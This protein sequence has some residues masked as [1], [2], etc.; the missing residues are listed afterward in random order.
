M[1]IISC[2]AL[3]KIM[4]KVKVTLSLD[5]DIYTT[6]KVY[7][8]QAGLSLSDLVD[9]MMLK[10]LKNFELFKKLQKLT[11]EELQDIYTRFN[12]AD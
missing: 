3:E 4:A 11:P 2:L 5:E 12:I 6:F 10:E 1:I 8:S 9:K 7:K